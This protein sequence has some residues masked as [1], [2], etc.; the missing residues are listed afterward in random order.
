MLGCALSKNDRLQQRL[1]Q[2]RPGVRSLPG[3]VI[4]MVKLLRPPQLR[5]SRPIRPPQLLRLR[6]NK[7]VLK[8]NRMLQL[9]GLR[10]NNAR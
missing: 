4:P 3:N 2:R 1:R 5:V 9:L 8:R 6:R 7:T 10:R